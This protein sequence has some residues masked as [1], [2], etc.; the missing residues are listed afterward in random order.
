MKELINR[1]KYVNKIL[2][3]KDKEYVKILVGVRRAGKSSIL[4]LIQNELIRTGIHEDRIVNINFEKM[5]FD[6]LKSPESFNSYIAKRI[7]NNIKTYIF[8]DE[9]QELKEWARVINSINVSY[10]VDI[11]ITGSNSNLFSG[12]HLTYLSGRYVS[13]EILPLSLMEI[14]HFLKGDKQLSEYYDTFKEGSFPMLI[15]EQNSSNKS[16][17]IDDLYNAVYLRDIILRAKVKNT[18]QLQNVGRF[19]FDSIG[20]RISAK[21]IYDSLKNEDEHLSSN[22]ISTY[23]S[24]FESAYLFYHCKRYDV[25]GKKLLQTHGK[26]YTVDLAL[27]K[28]ISSNAFENKGHILENFVFLELKKA[29]YNVQTLS[30]NRDYE[31][32]FLAEKDSK[33][34]FIQVSL[35]IVDENTFEREIRPF[36]YIRENGERYLVTLDNFIFDIPECKHINVFKFLEEVIYTEK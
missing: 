8:I 21:N 26:F 32:D 24:L 6:N 34:I 30:V 20:K 31:I 14:K 11:Y 22:T 35:S 16:T 10:D 12:H 7:S 2:S 3:F 13:F 19:L 1:E 36:K 25:Q 33:K 27:A 4:K 18:K 15:F 23:L 17:L 5:E 29:G 9:V 28:K